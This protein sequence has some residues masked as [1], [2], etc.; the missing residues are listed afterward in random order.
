MKLFLFKRRI[1]PGAGGVYLSTCML[2]VFA[3]YL[4]PAF[5]DN[6]GFYL[7]G[8]PSLSLLSPDT[9]NTRFSADDN[10]EIGGKLFLG[11][12]F[13]K[14]WGLEIFYSV[15]GEVDMTPQGSI[16]Y[17]ALYGFGG[18][19]SW[20]HNQQGLSGFLKAGGAEFDVN[21]ESI[22]IEKENDVQLFLGVGGR[23]NFARGWG[24]RLEYD[25]FSS[26]VQ[27]LTLSV[28]RRFLS[29][30]KP[31]PVVVVQ[32]R[33][34]LVTTTAAIQPE[35]LS[36]IIEELE[37]QVMDAPIVGS[38]IAVFSEA[39][40]FDGK[41]PVILFPFDSVMLTATGRMQAG[42]VAKIL[43]TY[44]ELRLEVQGYRCNV[45]NDDYGQAPSGR[46]A[47]SVADY[48]I[49]QGVDRDRLEIGRYGHRP[50]ASNAPETSQARDRRVEF[51]VLKKQR[52]D[53]E[54]GAISE[55]QRFGTDGRQ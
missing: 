42:T 18:V 32:S 48:M 51:I 24:A 31:A 43:R 39:A 27:L 55:S 37:P 54:W 40:M 23:Y 10:I 46:C 3:L 50:V 1:K 41:L 29:A 36:V 20:S 9:D 13:G 14:H 16:E 49:K 2:L 15:P 19:F 25:Y 17:S 22:F 44:P 30:A 12:D 35:S 33:P 52:L 21:S 34:A 38:D 28:V 45:D 4:A 47:Q 5:A 11:Y 8:G 26:D 53:Q 7:G 6:N